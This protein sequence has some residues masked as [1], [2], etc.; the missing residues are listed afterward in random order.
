MIVSPFPLL[1]YPPPIATVQLNVE[2]PSIIAAPFTLRT[3]VSVLVALVPPFVYSPPILTVPVNVEALP[4]VAVPV[5]VEVPSTD[6]API[7]G[8]LA[9][10]L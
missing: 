3:P 9:N 1:V 7:G 10:C 2:A 6:V 5:K 8:Y 4:T